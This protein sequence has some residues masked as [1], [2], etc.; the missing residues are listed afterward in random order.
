MCI[1]KCASREQM[2]QAQQAVQTEAQKAQ[3]ELANSNF[4]GY[5]TDELVQVIFNGNQQPVSTSLTDDAMSL[6]ADQLSAHID[7]AMQDAHKQSVDA[8][9]SR[10]SELA[11]SLGLPGADGGGSQ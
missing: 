6:S 11:G 4:E 9:R 3:Q 8:M 7:E 1:E 10:M 5:D 2:K